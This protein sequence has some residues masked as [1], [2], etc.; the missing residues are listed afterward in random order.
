M[1]ANRTVDMNLLD[2]V[3]IAQKFSLGLAAK[4]YKEVK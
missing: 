1:E 4:F 3:D 2:P